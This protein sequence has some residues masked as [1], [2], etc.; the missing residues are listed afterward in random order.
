MN[1]KITRQVTEEKELP[2]KPCIKC[3]KSDIKLWDCGYSSFNV[4]GINCNSCDRK[5]SRI[6]DYTEEQ[7]VE[8]WNSVNGVL[9]DSQ[10]LNILRKQIEELGKDPLV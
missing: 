7:L 8:Y 4:C 10:K 2:V 9:T 5:L 1:Y 3:G 6:G